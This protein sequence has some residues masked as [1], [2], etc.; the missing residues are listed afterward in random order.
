[1]ILLLCLSVAYYLDYKQNPELFIEKKRFIF[2]FF[3][4]C[5]LLCFLFWFWMKS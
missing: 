2:L 5:F 3:L 4:V 1:M